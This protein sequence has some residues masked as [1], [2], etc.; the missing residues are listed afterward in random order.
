M[1]RRIAAGIAG[2][3][4]TGLGP[5]GRVAGGVC[6]AAGMALTLLAPPAAA[7]D[8]TPA[9]RVDG[10]VI[11][12]YELTQR[13]RFLT[14]LRAPGDV[15]A[16]AL[17]QLVNE[18]LQVR[19]A[20]KVDIVASDE[21]IQDGIDE[22]AARGNLSGEQF[23][24][25]LAQGGIAAET[26]RDFVAAGVT[27]RQFVQANFRPMV[28]LSQAEIAIAMGEAEPEAGLRV[29]LS[30][31][32]LP[33][34]DPATR[35]ASQ[36]RAERLVGIDEE[37]F[38]D[39]AKRFSVSRTRNDAG[40]MSW[41]D[42]ATLP[43]AI[44]A[45]VRALQPGQTTRPIPVEDQIRLYYM[46]DREQVAGGTPATVVDYAALLLAGGASE[47]N[48]AAAAEI[49]ADVTGCDDLYAYGR[50]LPPEQLIREE[51][52]ETAVPAP[53]GAELATLDPGEISARVTTSNGALAVLMLCAR[54]N[55]L[56]RSLTEEA[57]AAG[58][59]NSRMAAMAQAYL[60]ELKANAT[61]EI[62]R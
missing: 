40:D 10:E 15:R 7:Q 12:V 24:Q 49:R 62:L 37:A 41:L 44:G 17:D 1:M 20:E 27:W 16:L 52:R 42:A 6:L 33:A 30:E 46:R 4:A 19:E 2:K 23:L 43:P 21:E 61:I 48:L 31:I 55:E 32:A 28:S 5:M 60:D 8:F 56:P 58:L 11:T 36:K 34:G 57:V 59:Q 29:L 13:Q 22:F 18:R 14:L 38:R 9:A 53:F 25:L 51:V 50:G 26:V 45:A 54:G 35:R 3:I 47:A 39:A